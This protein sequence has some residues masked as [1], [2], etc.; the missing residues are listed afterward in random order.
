MSRR[1]AGRGHDVSGRGRI[2][3]FARVTS[4]SVLPLLLC[5]PGLRNGALTLRNHAALGGIPRPII[6]VRINDCPTR[7]NRLTSTPPSPRA[8]T[9]C[10]LSLGRVNMRTR[11]K[12]E[13]VLLNA[14]CLRNV[15]GISKRLRTTTRGGKKKE[16]HERLALQDD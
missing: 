13:K 9:R 12:M 5:G 2:L 3:S 7:T 16:V 11:D 15:L 10:P 1:G 6:W 14:I 4:S 8:I